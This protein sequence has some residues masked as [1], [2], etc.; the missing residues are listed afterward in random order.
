VAFI[1]RGAQLEALRQKGLTVRSAAGDFHLGSVRATSEPADVGV[2]DWILFAVKAYDTAS[3]LTA[4]RPMVGESTVII[5][6]QNGIGA[7]EELGRAFGIDRIVLAPT[8]IVSNVV[9]PGVVA[10]RSAF[11]TMIVGEV[12][13]A[14]VT[15]RVDAI[16]AEF[17]K[18]GIDASTVPDGRVPLWDKFVFLSSTAG[19]TALARSEPHA[20]FE[21]EEASELLMEALEEAYSVG[22]ALGIALG[23]DTV[24]RWH[25][26]A[27]SLKPGEKMSMHLDL[28]RG[29]R[30]E[31]DALSGAVATLGRVHGVATP[32]HRTIHVA[33][34]GEDERAQARL[35]DALTSA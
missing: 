24:E 20:L 25:R 34:K 27:L 23:E 17:K 14:V 19:L 8:R 26:F 2:V 31:I 32:V 9:A 3:A 29:N 4:V 1:A 6:M 12:G 22:R 10:Q 16:A 15:P 7:P 11:R 18:A 13:G 35:R 5:T 28:E 30:L 21:H 33:L